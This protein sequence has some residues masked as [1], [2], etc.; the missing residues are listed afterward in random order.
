MLVVALLVGALWLY[1][2]WEERKF[3]SEKFARKRIKSVAN[4]EVP[5]KA[6]M[7]YHYYNE[8]WQDLSLQ[9][10]VFTFLEEPTDWLTNA[11]FSK[12]KDEEFE[13]RFRIPEWLQSEKGLPN[14]YVPSFENPYYWLKGVNVRMV[15]IPD[16]SILIVYITDAW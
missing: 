4:L 2:G 15:Y 8:S 9:Y 10:T 13:R 11:S 3:N 14:E 1:G 7:V 6:E 5:T 16:T 12:E